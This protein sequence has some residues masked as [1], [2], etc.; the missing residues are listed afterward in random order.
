MESNLSKPA[1]NAAISGNWGDA[2]TLNKKILSSNPSDIDAL[3][4]L[5]R[6][7]AEIGDI[8][9]AKIT[10]KKVTKI[11][12]YNNIAQK[13]LKKWKNIKKISNGPSAPFS[14]QLFL[15]EPGKTKLVILIHLG[16]ST[17]IANVDAGDEVRLNTQGHRVSVFTLN[18][19]Y[20]GRLPD[21]ISARINKLTSLGNTYQT[22]VKC[23]NEDDVKVFIREKERSKKLKD[24][25]SFSSEKIDYVS[26]TSPELVHSRVGLISQDEDG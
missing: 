9:R 13:S 2:V 18:G 24:T 19:K 26:F 14:P 16:G 12:P 20:L 8:K 7:Y 11:D 22:H 5:A 15:E 6:A 25:P 21:D 23:S 1:V 3:N 4:R 10:A 17:T